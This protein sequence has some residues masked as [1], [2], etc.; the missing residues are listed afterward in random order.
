MSLFR[1]VEGKRL[2]EARSTLARKAANG[3]A[4]FIMLAA[5]IA[6][7]RCSVPDPAPVDG[8]ITVPK[9]PD[10]IAPDSNK[11]RIDRAVEDIKSP[12]VNPDRVYK[13]PVGS[14]IPMQPDGVTV[15][16]DSSGAGSGVQQV[17]AEIFKRFHQVI[18]RGDS[19]HVLLQADS[20]DYQ[21]SYKIPSWQ[22][23]TATSTREGQPEVRKQR[24][25]VCDSGLRLGIGYG[26]ATDYVGP[27]GLAEGFI[28]PLSGNI[29]IRVRAEAAP[30]YGAIGAFIVYTF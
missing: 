10:H 16:V 8:V 11:S 2:S 9:L 27:V 17:P 25:L 29:E 19:I 13:A 28:S 24:C 7:G 14:S 15:T 4:L 22:D 3:A 12:K 23:W 5:A 30:L 21:Y 18:K 1:F 26:L 20:S 6:V